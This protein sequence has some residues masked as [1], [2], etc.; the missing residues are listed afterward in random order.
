M[1]RGHT[2]KQKNV[3]LH[4]VAFNPLWLIDSNMVILGGV[5]MGVVLTEKILVMFGHE[6]IAEVIST[7]LQ[8]FF[9]F[10]AVGVVVFFLVTNPILSWL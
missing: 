2:T 7:T 8:S 6:E 9:P 4:S 3:K 10:V 5:V 1:L